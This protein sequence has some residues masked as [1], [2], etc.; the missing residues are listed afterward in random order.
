LWCRLSSLHPSSAGWKACTTTTSSATPTPAAAEPTGD[1]YTF[2]K[3]VKV[4]GA[5]SR[6]S[7]GE[8]GAGFVDVWKRG[9]FAWEYKRNGRPRRSRAGSAAPYPV[10]RDGTT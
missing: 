1:D 3:P 8:G 10:P 6:G 9:H 5:A 4:V 7:K 2:E